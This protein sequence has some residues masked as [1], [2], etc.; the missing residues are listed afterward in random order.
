MSR[1]GTA[2]VTGGGLRLG[3]ALAVGLAEFGYRIALH[4]NASRDEAEATAGEIRR[5]GGTCLLFAADFRDDEQILDLPTRVA[6]QCTDLNLLVNNASVYAP[7][8]LA[9]TSAQALDETLQINFKAPFLLIQRFAAVCDAGQVINLADAKTAF[10]QFPYAAYILSKR[11]LLDLT[12]L[13]AVELAPRIRVN[14]VSPG[15]ILPPASRTPEYLEWR[16]QALP[17]QRFGQ[18]RHVLHAV[19]FLIEN[20]FVTG[21]CI[22]VDGGEIQSVEGRN[23]ASFSRRRGE[24]PDG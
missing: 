14:A 22:P 10:N 20:D 6:A 16:R 24:G 1:R 7:G 4:F 5:Q 12:R 11:A 23:T 17:L 9:E 18:P 21:A 8:T 15:V 19:R 2:L 13:A 3:R